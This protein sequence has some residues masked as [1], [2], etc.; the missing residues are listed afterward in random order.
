[1]ESQEWQLEIT[2]K[3][4][5]FVTHNT[6]PKF[7]V[8]LSINQGQAVLT[9]GHRGVVNPATG[10]KE[11]TASFKVV[12]TDAAFDDLSWFIHALDF[13]NNHPSHN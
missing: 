7:K 11:I 4:E 8:Q 5:I 9:G 1:M 3:G 13:Y 2:E 6:E 10:H 12:Q